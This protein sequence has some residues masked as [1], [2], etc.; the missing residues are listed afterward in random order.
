ADYHCGSLHLPGSRLDGDGHDHA[1]LSLPQPR[2]AG[3]ASLLHAILLS[4]ATTHPYRL[5]GRTEIEVVGSC[6]CFVAPINATVAV[7]NSEGGAGRLQQEG[8]AHHCLQP[9]AAESGA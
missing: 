1:A 8:Q 5:T 7:T 6:G 4:R 9:E 3:L 2:P